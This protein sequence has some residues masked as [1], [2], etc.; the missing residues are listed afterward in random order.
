MKWKIVTIKSISKQIRGVS[1]TPKDVSSVPLEGHI[2]L[3]RANNITESGID[4]SDTVFV[5]QKCISESQKL[6]VGDILIAA[7]SGSIKIVGKAIL[8]EDEINSSFGAFC[9]VIRPSENVDYRYLSYYF[10]SS[11]YRQKISHLAAGANINNLR[12]EDLDNLEIPLPPLPIQKR[13]A[14]ILDAADALR[15]KDQELLSKYDEL[16]QAIFID[17]FGDPVKNEKGWEVKKLEEVINFPSGLVD[18]RLNEYKDMYHVGGDNIDSKTGRIFGLKQAKELG[19]ISGK[20]YFTSNHILYN[21]IRPYLNKV[22]LPD[23]NGICSADMYPLLP[24]ENEVLK[25]YLYFIMRSP[26]FLDFADK[27]SR[28][29]NI[30]KINMTEMSLFELPVPPIEIQSKFISKLGGLNKNIDSVSACSD[31]STNLFDSLLQQSFKGELA[32]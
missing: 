4:L 5:N 29:A 11:D 24:K 18:P 23:F 14:E 1:Y 20:F 12:N 25:E 26:F 32:K 27:Q 3:L 15:R 30:P 19:L 6:K 2:R 28:R 21:K 8:I 13:I 17:M 22:A 31:L 10:R 7:S 16:A 9:K